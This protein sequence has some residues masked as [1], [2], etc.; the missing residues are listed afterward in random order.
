M[1]AFCVYVYV[2]ACE[3]IHVELR[4]RHTRN[5]LNGNKNPKSSKNHKQHAHFWYAYLTLISSWPMLSVSLHSI[6]A[7]YELIIES[8]SF[9]RKKNINQWSY[10]QYFFKSNVYVFF[11][12]CRVLFIIH[13]G[14]SDCSPIEDF[15]V[16]IECDKKKHGK[17]STKIGL[18]LHWIQTHLKH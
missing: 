18:C 17:Q 16:V 13:L 4:L 10:L 15:V 8:F 12:F 14:A 2:W 3:H 9:S 6:H 11:T 1:R 7:A 5:K